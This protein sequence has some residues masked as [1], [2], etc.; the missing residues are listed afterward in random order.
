MMNNYIFRD[1]LCLCCNYLLKNIVLLLYILYIAGCSKGEGNSTAAVF[2]DSSYN[3]SGSISPTDL[4]ADVT[5]DVITLRWKAVAGA[6][7]Y[8]VYKDG[9]QIVGVDT[10]F[11]VDRKL[12]RG[13]VYNYQ[14]A[15]CN[16]ISCSALSDVLLVPTISRSPTGLVAED[17]GVSYISLKW[18]AVAGAINY[19]IYRDGTKIIIINSETYIDSGLISE[20]TYNYHV[21]ACNSSGCSELSDIISKKTLQS[22]SVPLTPKNIIV[23]GNTDTSI[24]L[25]WNV[26]NQ[27]RDYIVYRYNSAGEFLLS[28]RATSIAYV[29]T[30]LLPNTIYKY[31]L[32]ACNNMGC[33]SVAGSHFFEAHT[34]LAAPNNLHISYIAS[35]SLDLNWNIVEGAINYQIYRDDNSLATISSNRFTDSTLFAGTIYDYQVLACNNRGC[36]LPSNILALTIP[37]LPVFTAINAGKGF[38][39]LSWDVVKGASRYE[40]TGDGIIGITSTIIDAASIEATLDVIIIGRV[41]INLM[42]NIFQIIGLD[43]STEYNYKIRA[44]NV[45]GCSDFIAISK[46]I[47]KGFAQLNIPTNLQAIDITVNGAILNWDLVMEAT[48]YKIIGDGNITIIGTKAKIAGLEAG[49]EYS[50]SVLAC[51]IS[52]CS[53][54]SDRLTVVTVPSKP[55]NLQARN[56]TA[57]SVDLDWDIVIGAEYYQILGSGNITIIGTKAKIAG[58]EARSEYSYSV[59]ACNISGCS[60]ESDRLTVVTVPLKPVNLQARNITA[61]SVDLDWDIVIGVEYYQ[62]LGSGDITIMGAKAKIA[63]LEAGSEYSYSVL[64]C[65]ISGCSAESDRLTV[66]TVPLKPVNLQARNIIA[67]SISLDWDIVIGAEHYQIYRNYVQ[68]SY[69]RSNNFIDTGL[70]IGDRNNYRIKACNDSGC[71]ELSKNLSVVAIP[72]VCITTTDISD[73]CKIQKEGIEWYLIYNIHQLQSI[74]S[75]DNYDK[76]YLLVNDIDAS[77]TRGWNEGAGFDPIGDCGMDNDCELGPHRGFSGN[78]NGNGYNI[79]NLYINRPYD[80]V[81]LFAVSSGGIDSLGVEAEIIGNSYVGILIGENRGTVRNSYVVGNVNGVNNVG[82]LSGWN[83]Q[84]L[85]N[86]YARTKVNG[87]KNVGGLL[88]YHSITTLSNSYAISSVSGSNRVGGLVGVNEGLIDKSYTVGEVNGRVGVG[89]LVGLN[90]LGI[91]DGVTVAIG[92]VTNSFWN[93]QFTGQIQRDISAIG[94]EL[95]EAQMQTD[96]STAIIRKL[97]NAWDFSPS[98]AYPRLKRLLVNGIFGGLLPTLVTALDATSLSFSEVDVNNKAWYP[99]VVVTKDGKDAVKSGSIDDNEN[100]CLTTNVIGS[101]VTF[102]WKVSSEKDKDY[103]LFYVDGIEK[104][105]I[106]GERDWEQVEYVFNGEIDTPYEI[107]WCYEK[108]NSKTERLDAGWLD[109]LTINL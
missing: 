86:L 31:K 22:V 50:Y 59:L 106:S 44:C 63:G 54:E 93:V 94:E 9:R 85:S 23:S 47:F 90:V 52:G 45:S 104:K 80:G 34:R 53:A 76:N 4:Q 61:I 81:G 1:L 15:A 5:M 49:S 70:T 18:D 26:G 83:N 28:N 88:G 14:V 62:I 42:D 21:A 33:S 25:T 56:I 98:N 24:T 55:V 95:T 17:I 40:V 107:K 60:A 78:F 103:L 77:A 36:S 87:M 66:V 43:A 71:S 75:T 74:D 64:A 108:N 58:L 19:Q 37:T 92:V 38:I 20:T 101:G 57:I 32:Q 100:S 2:T 65:N 67:T 3:F 79:T 11:Y 69:E 82:G 48:R 10:V 35:T 13:N 97:G 96:A 68:V 30:D 39:D 84:E 46:V 109:Q 91:I 105:A 12:I 29:D 16:N 41:T 73:D 51:N 89:G 102:W 6:T 99:Q 27:A 72:P 7:N 8:K